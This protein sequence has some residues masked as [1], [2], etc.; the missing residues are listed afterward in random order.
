MS[1]LHRDKRG[2]DNFSSIWKVREDSE[3]KPEAKRAQKPDGRPRGR[4]GRPGY[5]AN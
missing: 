1:G 5:G 2:T 4:G 3:N